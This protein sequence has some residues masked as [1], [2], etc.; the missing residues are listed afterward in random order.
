MSV[1]ENFPIEF[2]IFISL[3]YALLPKDHTVQNLLIFTAAGV[4]PCGGRKTS[5]RTSS[6]CRLYFLVLWD[7]LVHFKSFLQFYKKRKFCLIRCSVCV[8]VWGGGGGEGGRRG[9]CCTFHY[10]S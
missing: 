10:W 9:Q 3:M 2:A 7:H 4:L 6:Q 8:C 1:F 5:P